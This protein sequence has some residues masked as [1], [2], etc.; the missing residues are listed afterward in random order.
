MH[1][2]AA[3]KKLVA[4]IDEAQTSGLLSEFVTFAESLQLPYL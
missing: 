2:P 3:Y 1:N 4:E